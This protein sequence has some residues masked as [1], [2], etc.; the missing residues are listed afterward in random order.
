MR[1]S[2][3][4]CAA[5]LFK[6]VS[7]LKNSTLKRGS[8]SRRPRS[9]HSCTLAHSHNPRLCAQLIVCAGKNLARTTP[10]LIAEEV[11]KH[12]ISPL[13][14]FYGGPAVLVGPL[15]R[16]DFA[17][18]LGARVTSTVTSS[19]SPATA[20]NHAS[21]AGG[22]AGAMVTSGS[23][24]RSLRVGDGSMTLLELANQELERRSAASGFGFVNLFGGCLSPEDFRVH[25]VP[26][27]IRCFPLN[28]SDCSSTN[29]HLRLDCLQDNLHLRDCGYFKM[30]SAVFEVYA[31]AGEREVSDELG[32]AASS[33]CPAPENGDVTPY[34]DAGDTEAGTGFAPACEL[35]TLRTDLAKASL[36]RAAAER[37]LEAATSQ[38]ASALEAYERAKDQVSVRSDSAASG[39]PRSATCRPASDSNTLKTLSD[40]LSLVTCPIQT[41]T[42]LRDLAMAKKFEAAIADRIQQQATSH[43]VLTLPPQ[44]LVKQGRRHSKR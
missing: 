24:R 31:A 5:C 43:G 10:S 18:P 6:G 27:A 16:D 3:R 26:L 29:A 19:S 36:Q 41:R 13:K 1:H 38:E 9:S 22:A 15:T 7:T 44:E 40:P 34:I 35:N 4:E 20:T 28:G 12:L 14:K 39:P 21:G 23:A 25:C 42:R 11:H 17:P 2:Q 30:V 37:A 32:Q 8:C 33:P